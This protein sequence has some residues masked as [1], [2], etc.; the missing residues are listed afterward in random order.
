[1]DI[2]SVH[3]DYRM[4]SQPQAHRVCE[5][6]KRM[7]LGDD[8]VANRVQLCPVD[9]HQAKGIGIRYA[10]SRGSRRR[11][12]GTSSCSLDRAG[13]SGAATSRDARAHRGARV[14]AATPSKSRGTAPDGYHGDGTGSHELPVETD[15]HPLRAALRPHLGPV[16]KVATLPRNDLFRSNQNILTAPPEPE[17]ADASARGEQR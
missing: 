7:W 4:L 2:D 16:R 13:S 6:K 11:S 17:V 9:W 15:G 3:L 10:A 1:V 8:E 5:H 14:A 12:T